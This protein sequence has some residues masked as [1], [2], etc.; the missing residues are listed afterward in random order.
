MAHEC[1]SMNYR[2]V[3]TLITIIGVLLFVQ[4]GL[5]M[6]VNF[7]A[8]IPPDT[9][10][11]FFSYSD[12]IEVLAHIVNGSLILIIAVGIV[13]ISATLGNNLLPKLAVLA[14]IFVAAA[15]ATGLIFTLQAQDP[16]FSIAMAMSF[17][18]AYTVYFGAYFVS[19]RIMTSERRTANS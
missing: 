8:A 3:Q 16:A 5:G 15:V 1:Y 2:T 19:G 10:L 11:A 18:S 13:G 12:G 17:I 7:F 6:V 14:L 4:Y 9:P